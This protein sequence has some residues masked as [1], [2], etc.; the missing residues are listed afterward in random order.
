MTD[1]STAAP[2]ADTATPATTTPPAASLPPAAP[3]APQAWFDGFESP[4]VREWAKSKGAK[5]P[6]ALANSYWQLEKYVGADKA[7]RGVVIPK[8]DATPEER[9][10]FWGK[11]GRPESPAGYETPDI[12]G[13]PQGKAAEWF[14]AANLTK[15]QASAVVEAYGRFA[16]EAEESFIA[17]SKNEADELKREWGQAYDHQRELA[18]RAIR[19]AGLGEEDAIAIE[20]ALGVK[21]AA[22]AFAALGKQYAEAPMHE[23]DA[24]DPTYMT[25]ADAT[26]KKAVLMQDKDFAARYLNGDTGARAQMRRLEAVIAQAR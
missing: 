18:L 6:E 20:R 4:E 24:S 8:G 12:P 22:K 14:H 5:S 19:N 10:A 3:S 26:A 21:K 17:T 11:I 13:M 23:G 2:S 25:P 15:D 16:T 7:G 9:Q 1:A